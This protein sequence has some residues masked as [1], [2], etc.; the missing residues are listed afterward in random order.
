MLK[1]SKKTEYAILALQYISANKQRR[2]SVKEISD[3]LNI[4][5]E[6]LSKTLQT[7][8]KAGFIHSVQ[9]VRGGYELIKNPEEFTIMELVDAI[10]GNTSIVECFADSEDL[11]C[12][13]V[14]SCTIRGPMKNIQKKINNILN[15][16]TL[17]ELTR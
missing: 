16:T 7:L 5:F 8:M 1:F 14:D 15:T 12:E 11:T 10:D 4:S 13:R 6:F 9:G 3:N 2:I 17:A